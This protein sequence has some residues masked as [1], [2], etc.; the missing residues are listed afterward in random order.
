MANKFAVSLFHPALKRRGYQAPVFSR[1]VA[2]FFVSSD[3]QEVSPKGIQWRSIQELQKED[4]S[5][6]CWLALQ[7]AGLIA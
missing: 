3:L 2:V 1:V 5:T 6:R 4:C 7:A